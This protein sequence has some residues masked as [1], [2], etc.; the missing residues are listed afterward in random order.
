M[1]TGSGPKR[2]IVW[3]PVSVNSSTNRASGQLVPILSTRAVGPRWDISPA[4]QNT[5]TPHCQQSY[6]AN[7]KAAIRASLDPL[8]VK[9]RSKNSRDSFPHRS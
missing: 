6:V 5:N 8:T 2:F 3:L 4:N 7:L 9:N 1:R